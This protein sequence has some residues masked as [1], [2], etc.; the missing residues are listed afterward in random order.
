MME[1]IGN[2]F[3]LPAA[4]CDPRTILVRFRPQVFWVLVAYL[5]TL[6]A[7][8]NPPAAAYGE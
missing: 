1:H 6:I 4:K 5:I 2:Q 7:I 3:V 8:T